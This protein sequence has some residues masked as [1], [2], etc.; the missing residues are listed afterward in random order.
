[1]VKRPWPNK[2]MF[3]LQMGQKLTVSVGEYYTYAI[4]ELVSSY[5]T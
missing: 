4:N 1:M 3:C 5:M 2:I